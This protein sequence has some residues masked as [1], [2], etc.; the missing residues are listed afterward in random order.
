MDQTRKQVNQQTQQLVKEWNGGK[1]KNLAK[2][3]QMLSQLKIGL[4]QVS[5]LPTSPV[6]AV[7]LKQDLI[8]ARDVLEIGC[9][10]SVASRDT[11]SFER[12]IC[13]LKTYYFDYRDHLEASA[14]MYQILGLNLLRLLSQNRVADFHTE[15]ELLPASE[16]ASNVYISHPVCLEQ[17][18]M[19]GRYNKVFESKGNV[20]AASYCF[21]LETLLN[22][23]RV[24]IA[25][26]LESA[27]ERMTIPEAVKVL[28]FNSTQELQAFVQK[29]GKPWKTEG[30]DV[31]FGGRKEDKGLEK[32]PALQL[33]AQTISYARELEMIV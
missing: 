20:P 33:M 23:I 14:Y 5:F 17:W 6:D 28:L 31:L 22:T 2:V 27:Y 3:G 30:K 11:Q 9:L 24:E 4:T 21:F 12:Y 25:G 10:H 29:E 32:V 7:T 1:T 13:Q 19:E 26:C 18:L 16:I 8:L 15:L